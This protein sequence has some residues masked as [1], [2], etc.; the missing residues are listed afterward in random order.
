MDPFVAPDD[1]CGAA[2]RFVLTR[3]V[4]AQ[5][6]RLS[7]LA[8]IC[9]CSTVSAHSNRVARRKIVADASSRFWSIASIKT[10]RATVTLGVD[11]KRRN[12]ADETKGGKRDFFVDLVTVV[13]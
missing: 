12:R 1:L 6:K 7:S 8:M 5:G 4:D 9:C 3:D 13:Q 11:L 2:H 10:S